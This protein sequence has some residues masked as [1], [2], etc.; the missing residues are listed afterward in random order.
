MFDILSELT[1]CWDEE[2]DAEADGPIKLMCSSAVKLYPTPTG[3]DNGRDLV[4][5]DMEEDDRM[6]YGFEC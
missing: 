2:A 4:V 3:I 6:P 1:A 5:A